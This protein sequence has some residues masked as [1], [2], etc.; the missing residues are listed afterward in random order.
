VHN[1]HWT[2]ALESTVGWLAGSRTIYWILALAALLILSGLGWR[3]PWPA[4]EPRFALI[5]RDMVNTGQWLFPTRGGELYPD[6]PPLFMWMIAGIY[7]L[8]NNLRIAFLLPSALAALL[9]LSLVYDLTRRLW[10]TSIANQATLLLLAT[11]QFTLQAKTAQIDAVVTLWVT[12]GCY[13]LL[14]H[15]LLGPAITWYWLGCFAMGLGVITKGV[16]FLPFLLLLPWAAMLVTSSRQRVVNASWWMLAGL[17]VFLLAIALWW[18]P[19]SI[20]VKSAGDAAL[21]AYRQEILFHQTATR[22]ANTWTHVK[23]VYYYLVSVIPVFWLPISIA[24]PALVLR[25]YGAFRTRDP[26]IILPVVWIVL[27]IA[28]FSAS[29]GKRGVYLLPTVP[30]L[31]MVSAPFVQELLSKRWLANALRAVLALLSI[32]FTSIAFAGLVGTEVTRKLELQHGFAPWLLLL[33]L[34]LTSAVAAILCRRERVAIAW[35][36]FIVPLWLLYSTWGYRLINEARTPAQVYRQVQRI[37]DANAQI[38]LVNFREQYL[39]FAPRKITHFGFAT[40]VEEQ[41]RETWR[42]LAE[43]PD[44][45]ALLADSFPLAC[46]TSDSAIPVGRAHDKQWRL[47]SVSARAAYCPAPTNPVR[48]FDYQRTVR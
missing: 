46:F 18:L 17:P 14:R 44:R 7:W 3:D 34:G 45:Y 25:W 4:D 42:W 19:M 28:F 41:L 39:L 29:P 20:A 15:L 35:F 33:V 30:M 11:L 21:T 38:A 6:K 13:G 12:L 26:R 24:I 32:L 31:A 23:P 10:N 27:V 5:A 40:P 47:Y 8:T 16:G 48:R 37:T 43:S 22:Y 2:P 1:H 9:S 36:T